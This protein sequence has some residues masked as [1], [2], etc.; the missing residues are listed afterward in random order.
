MKKSF[1]NAINFD[2]INYLNLNNRENLNEILDHLAISI[3]FYIFYGRIEQMREM[4][5]HLKNISECLG[6]R[7]SIAGEPFMAEILRMNDKVDKYFRDNSFE[8]SNNENRNISKYNY[9]MKRIFLAMLTIVSSI[10]LSYFVVPSF[11]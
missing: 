9:Y 10:I 5:T 2:K 11:K 6:D 4:D 7:Y 3:P 8:F 1:G